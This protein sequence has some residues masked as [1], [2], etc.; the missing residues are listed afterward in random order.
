MAEQGVDT[1]RRRFLVAATTVVGGAGAAAVGAAFLS[2]WKPSARAQAAGAAVEADI[3]KIEPGAQISIEWR[4]QPVWIIRRSEEML[5]LL[6]EN[7]P[8]LRDPNSEVEQQPPYAANPTRSIKPEFAVLVG[9]C[10][11]LGCSPTFRPDIGAADLGGPEWKG[12]FYCPCHGSRFDLAGR[13]FQNVPAATNLRVP[14][15]TY[16]SDTRILVGE[17]GGAA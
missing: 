10:T 14:P 5:R 16:L 1:G 11:H 12:G 2:Y 8:R 13:V 17:D 15:H 4:G 6:P 9:I 7:D 3:S